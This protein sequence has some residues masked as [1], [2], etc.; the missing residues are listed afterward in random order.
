MGTKPFP[1]LYY[2]ECGS[3]VHSFI[4]LISTGWLLDTRH[5]AGDTAVDKTN[6]HFQFVLWVHRKQKKRWDLLVNLWPELACPW[7][8]VTGSAVTELLHSSDVIIKGY[9]DAPCQSISHLWSH[10]SV[11]YHRCRGPII[12]TLWYPSNYTTCVK[13]IYPHFMYV[14]M[15]TYTHT[16]GISIQYMCTLFCVSTEC[17]E[18]QE[19]PNHGQHQEGSWYHPTRGRFTLGGFLDSWSFYSCKHQ[20][21][22]KL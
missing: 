22:Q 15:Y 20:H 17:P 10:F 7:C 4:Q 14:C 13:S 2:E 9:W 12:K 3:S 21:Y 16:Y 18:S 8:P 5:H 19:A 1:V 11:C 6:A